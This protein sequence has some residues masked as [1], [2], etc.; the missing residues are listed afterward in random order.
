MTLGDDLS[1]AHAALEMAL[2]DAEK[3]GAVD[4]P[5]YLVKEQMF[6]GREHLPWI[7]QLLQS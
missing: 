6:V 2:D 4:T 5:G 3:E 1:K 7:R